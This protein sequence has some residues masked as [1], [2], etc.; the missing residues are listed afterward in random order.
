MI[1]INKVN[2]MNS[3]KARLLLSSVIVIVFFGI[4]TGIILDRA[5]I[6]KATTAV[7]LRLQSQI[8]E[9]ISLDEVDEKTDLD[10]PK[11]LLNKRLLMPKSG[12]YA[13]VSYENKII[14]Q[15]PSTG[16]LKIPYTAIVQP[17]EHKLSEV[18]ASDGS[19]LFLLSLGYVWAND[20]EKQVIYVFHVA[21]TD[22]HY[23]R[24]LHYF[25]M[26]LW[27]LL[28]I[29]VILMVLIQIIVLNWGLGPLARLRKD[30]SDIEE[31]KRE[32]LDSNYVD[33]IRN[34]T[35]DLNTL[36][37]FERE[38]QKRYR[39]S[40][41][42][43]AHSFKTSLSI[44]NSTVNNDRINIKTKTVLIEQVDNLTDLVTYHL[45]RAQAAG[46]KASLSKPVNVKVL[47]DKI[48]SALKK[49]H[50]DKNIVVETDIDAKAMFYGD[51]GDLL[52]VL[53]NLLDNACKWCNSKVKLTVTENKESDGALLTLVVEDDG[54]G[55]VDD[56]KQE[57]LKR[58]IRADEKIAGHGIGM[59][60]LTDIVAAYSGDI[61]VSDSELGG[62]KFIVYFK[63]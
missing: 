7:S 20:A 15:S 41:G 40:L 45:R 37:K 50:Q 34:L 35:K 58:G 22:K 6:A 9:L 55:I 30:L 19:T 54:P 8:Y 13:A 42:D 47:I 53:G 39:N 2:L 24:D 29:I 14:W 44:I 23:Q 51:K 26:N 46:T 25:R 59:S 63:H 17:G 43:L 28:V 4:L 36:L 49:V 48:V 32:Y 5:F 52:E 31:G 56:K 21:E 60:I 38:R 16:D 62:A 61:S 10:F 1:I 3:L 11:N 12:Y 57:I 27:R 18:K 33:E